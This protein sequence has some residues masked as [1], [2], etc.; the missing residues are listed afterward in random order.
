MGVGL[1]RGIS[2]PLGC[3]SQLIELPFDTLASVAG[4][5]QWSPMPSVCIDLTVNANPTLS[6]SAGGLA[7][8]RFKSRGQFD[9]L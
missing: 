6:P 5:V 3:G 2:Q 8:W 9:G 7:T 4:A 1:K